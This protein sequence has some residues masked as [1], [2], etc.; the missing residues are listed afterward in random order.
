VLRL[1]DTAS[2]TVRPLEQRDPGVV[3]MYVCGP[4][5]YGEP[6][7]GNTRPPIVFDVLRRYLEFIGTT[8]RYASNITDVDDKI[9]DKA[10]TEGRS[11]ADVANEFETVYW[12]IMDALG[13]RRPDETP[14]ATK[15]IDQMVSLVSELIDIGIA[16]ETPD[17]V[18][19]SVENVDGY[20]LLA[21]QSL[22]SL[23]SGARVDVDE[24]K[25]SPLDFALWKGAKPGEPHWE[26]PFGAGRPGW[27]TECVVMSLGLLGE[28]FDLHGGGRDLAF[29]HHENE[30]AQAVALGKR[31]AQHWMHNGWVET[32]GE[33]VSKSLGNFTSLTEMLAGSDA[34]V[35]RLL[36]LR[37]HYRSPVEVTPENVADAEAALSR[38]DNLA[39]R[40]DLSPELGALDARAAV[41]SGADAESIAEFEAKMDDD[42]DTPG[43]VALI[44]DLAKRAN[45]LAD[46]EEERQASDLASTV[47]ILCG[48]LGLDLRPGD[49]D[50]PEPALLDLLARRN[51]ARAGGNFAEA[52]ELR[53][54]IRANGWELEDGTDGSRLRRP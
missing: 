20:G 51:A 38:L 29:P 31:F 41:G 37:S 50:V 18:Y 30:R 49:T 2:G 4:T 6:H 9:I 48:A 44:F 33:K 27:H 47:A 25:R 10:R 34:R 23:R 16:Y 14:H 40:F 35:Y 28:G 54:E 53:D 17:G 8:V 19:L 32:D 1:Y 21:K 43:A 12:G 24:Q 36:F 22:S 52:D 11:D 39:R 46:K 42:L 7:L 45:A 26:A 15:W 3:T 5:V 13:V